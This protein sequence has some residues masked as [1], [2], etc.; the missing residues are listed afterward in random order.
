MFDTVL[1][2]LDGTPAAE[3]AIPFGVD[4]AT[5]HGSGLVLLRVIPRPE[6]PLRSRVPHGGPAPAR[7]EW[8][9]PVLAEEERE[10]R[11]YLAGVVE[12]FALAPGT[13]TV[14][15]VGEPYPRL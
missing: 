7:S 12:R 11:R 10:V 9:G 5:R 3:A 13:E 6:L 1:V 4:E 15:A 2:L 8:D 14:C